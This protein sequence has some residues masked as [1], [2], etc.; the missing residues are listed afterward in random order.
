MASRAC[1]TCSNE[2]LG[3]AHVS[4]FPVWPR[5][6]LPSEIRTLVHDWA[7][8]AYLASEELRLAE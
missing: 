2:S 6:V 4:I 1:R 7:N 3:V 8:I 5:F